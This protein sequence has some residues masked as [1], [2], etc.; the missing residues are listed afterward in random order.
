VIAPVL[1]CPRCSAP[2]PYDWERCGTCGAQR[3]VAADGAHAGFVALA[4]PWRRAL[5]ALLDV[6]L[7][8]IPTAI[9]LLV[10]PDRIANPSPAAGDEDL[11]GVVV[12]ALLLYGPIAIGSRGR[13]LG[14]RVVKVH[15]VADD[16]TAPT[17]PRAAVREGVGKVLL[18]ASLASAVICVVTL[19]RLNGDHPGVATSDLVVGAVAS[20]IGASYAGAEVGLLFAGR[21]H[22]TLHD[23]MAGTAVVT[24][25]PL[26]RTAADPVTALP[27]RPAAPPAP[28]SGGPAA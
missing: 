17:Y 18:Y 3:L 8:A 28:A 5:A 12:L 9:A 16:G 1:P 2:T 14:K 22:R 20:F 24:G 4:S 7:F 21:R 10:L 15:V 6:A 11:L 26:S 13:T 27:D 25:Q 23:A 19:V